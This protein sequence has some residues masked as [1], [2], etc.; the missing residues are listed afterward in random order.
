MFL[1]YRANLRAAT[2]PASDLEDPPARRLVT[3]VEYDK[4]G[5]RH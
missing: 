1:A 3:R 5:W 4:D 2:M